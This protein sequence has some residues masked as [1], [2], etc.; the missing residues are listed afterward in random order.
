MKTR[1]RN[2]F[3]SDDVRTGTFQQYPRGPWIS[4]ELFR[5]NLDKAQNRVS[6]LRSIAL[7]QKVYV[8]LIYRQLNASL[9]LQAKRDL[10]FLLKQK[11]A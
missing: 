7:S 2:R 8:S 10:E 5:E 4:R 11:H 1:S 6:E 3:K 9:Y